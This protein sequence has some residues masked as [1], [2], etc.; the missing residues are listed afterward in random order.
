MLLEGDWQRPGL[1]RWHPTLSGILNQNTINSILS[2]LKL[3]KS[4]RCLRLY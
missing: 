4:E 2:I 1:A 3:F